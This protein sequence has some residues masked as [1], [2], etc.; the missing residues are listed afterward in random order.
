[1]LLG[2]VPDPRAPLAVGAATDRGEPPRVIN[3]TPGCRFR[4]RCPLAVDA[5]EH[6]TPQLVELAPAHSAACHVAAANAG[7]GDLAVSGPR[8]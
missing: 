1:M 6:I 7:L 4:R 2:A 5:C 3:P 8:A